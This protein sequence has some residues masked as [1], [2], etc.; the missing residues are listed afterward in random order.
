[1]R[2]PW[3]TQVGREEGRKKETV[4]EKNEDQISPARFESHARKIRDILKMKPQKHV[5]SRDLDTK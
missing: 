3:D 2:F 4:L 1:M 5:K